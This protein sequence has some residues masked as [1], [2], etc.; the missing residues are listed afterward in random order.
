M[1][2]QLDTSLN[3]PRLID[4][5]LVV[6]ESLPAGAQPDEVMLRETGDRHS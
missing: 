1:H 3:Y 6:P 5:Y 4:D 2:Q